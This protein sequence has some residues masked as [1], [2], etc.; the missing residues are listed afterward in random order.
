MAGLL[1]LVC[2]GFP[3][4]ARA[5]GAAESCHRLAADPDDP[6]RA[7]REAGVPDGEMTEAAI[8]ACE[9]AV[10]AAPE[11]PVLNYQLGR[12]L[13]EWGRIEEALAPIGRAA[14]AGEPA[15]LYLHALLLRE[16][17]SATDGE[18]AGVLDLSLRGG[19]APAA[20][21]LDQL[22]YAPSPDGTTPEDAAAPAGPDY[23]RFERGDIIEALVTGNSDYL[24]GLEVG[25][26]SEQFSGPIAFVKYYEGLSAALSQ[27]YFCP[28]LLPAGAG[29][30]LTARISDQTLRNTVDDPAAMLEPGGGLETM[31]G[32]LQAMV[33]SPGDAMRRQVG[34][35]TALT[36]LTEQG[37]K[38]GAVLRILGEQGD[39]NWGCEGVASLALAEGVRALIR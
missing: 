17:G 27:P 29:A 35:E 20:I 36:L 18:V 30:I 21:A 10:T 1:L 13:L 11:D 15:A 7:T 16:T 2:F 28:A 33:P 23:G 12:A 4:S 31:L 9:A 22:G 19:Y 38:D 32:Q 37:T 6:A 24:R 5:D 8:S 3:L 14:Q 25:I 34:G 26:L 39:P